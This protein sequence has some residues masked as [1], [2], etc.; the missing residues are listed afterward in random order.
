LRQI[1]LTGPPPAALSLALMQT[2]YRLFR[3]FLAAAQKS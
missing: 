1:P 2:P 3:E